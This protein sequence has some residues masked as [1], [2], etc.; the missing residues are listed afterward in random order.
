MKR[1]SIV[2]LFTVV[3]HYV[4]VAALASKV[5]LWK[6]AALASGVVAGALFVVMMFKE[7]GGDE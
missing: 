4:F 5:P 2:L 3:C 7:M 6:A 1:F